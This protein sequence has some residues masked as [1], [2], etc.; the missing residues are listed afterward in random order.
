[1]IKKID[2]IQLGIFVLAVVGMVGGA[3]WDLKST[4]VE[5]RVEMRESFK[6]SVEDRKEIHKNQNQM[7]EKFNTIADRQ[8]AVIRTLERHDKRMQDDFK[9]ELQK[10][11]FE[12]EKNDKKGMEKIENNVGW[13]LD[14]QH[15]EVEKLIKW[16][17][18]RGEPVQYWEEVKIK[19]YPES[20]ER[21]EWMYGGQWQ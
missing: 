20:K 12:H 2:L 14:N 11:R 6:Q 10:Q 18:T 4:V 13:K 9:K 19:P 21:P 1:M 15:A 5:N 8:N 3:Y 17:E 16:Y 7:I